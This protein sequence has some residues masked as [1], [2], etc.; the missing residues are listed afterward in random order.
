MLAFVTNGDKFAQCAN[1]TDITA[2]VKC[3]VIS[4]QR[5]EPRDEKA[6]FQVMEGVENVE[7]ASECSA[8]ATTPQEGE[9]TPCFAF[10]V[11]VHK[12]SRR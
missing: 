8:T 10:R 5:K 12:S 1:Y 9:S 6:D 11:T 2:D 7:L 4:W 3:K